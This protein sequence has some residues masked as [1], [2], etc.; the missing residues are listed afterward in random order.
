MR[1]FEPFQVT[2]SNMASTSS[3]DMSL[4]NELY[5]EMERNPPAIEARKILVQ[6]LMAVGWLGAAGDEAKNILEFAPN[7]VDALRF[8]SILPK[9]GIQPSPVSVSKSKLLSG[10]TPSWPL[11]PPSLPSDLDAAKLE[12]ERD[13][14]A[15]RSNAQ[16]LLRDSTLLRDLTWQK[17]QATVPSKVNPTSWDRVLGLLGS[18]EHSLKGGLPVQ[19]EKGISTRFEKHIPDLE[20]LANGRVSTVVRGKTTSAPVSATTGSLNV[21]TI[22]A[23]LGARSVART[24]KAEPDKAVEIAFNDLSSMIG[25]LKSSQ[26]ST[27]DD[28]REAMVKRVKALKTNLP[29]N[30]HVHADSAQMHVEHEILHRVYIV[31]ETMYGDPVVDIPR[32]NFLVTEGTTLLSFSNFQ[33]QIG[34]YNPL[35]LPH[36]LFVDEI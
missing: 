11:P 2:I 6:Q 9:I 35:T 28:T 31:T 17:E 26:K 30:L 21:R 8:L 19:K 32:S 24:M 12:L 18:L 4:I 33:A 36:F 23:P 16:I 29:E 1:K 5:E 13:Y 25:W 7:D 3:P 20:N 14:K 22:R 34:G 27:E 15:L 10:N